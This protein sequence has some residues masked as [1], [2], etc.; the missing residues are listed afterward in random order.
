VY[1]IREKHPKLRQR[2]LMFAAIFLLVASPFIWENLE[3]LG[4]RL[5][6]NSSFEELPAERGSIGGRRVLVSA[7]NEVFAN[8]AILGVGIGASPQA[9]ERE[10]PTM[11]ID[12]QP[13]HVVLLTAAVETGLIG[14]MFYLILLSAPWV[15]I[16]TAR[17]VKMTPDLIAASALLLALTIIGLFDY[18]PWML[19]TGRLWQY[20]AWGLW[21][22]AYTKA[23]QI[24]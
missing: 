12:Y 10:F 18:Y 20:L 4:V 22:M 9:F 7:A 3:L 17:S 1:V 11:P 16:F 14:A 13:A 19:T 24:A 6:A 8:N 15:A 5:G 21:A 2:A 23:T